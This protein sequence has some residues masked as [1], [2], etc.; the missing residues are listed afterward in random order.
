MADPP[1]VMADPIGHPFPIFV[2]PDLT[3]RPLPRKSLGYRT[4]LEY[5]KQLFNFDF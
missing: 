2:M 4:P 5:Y 3:G 1:F